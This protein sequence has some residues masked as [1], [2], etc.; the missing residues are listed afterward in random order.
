MTTAKRPNFFILLGLNPDLPWNQTQFENALRN[1]RNDWS[2]QGAG[3]ARQALAAKQNLAL[4]PEINRVMNNDDEREKEADR[5]RAELTSEHKT[6][7]E[8]FKKHLS[9]INAKDTIEEV[10]VNKFIEDFKDV[11]SAQEIKDRITIKI[12]PSGVSAGA[13]KQQLDKTKAKDIADRLQLLH[14]ST[15]YEL[16][17]CPPQTATADLCRAAEN[18]YSKTVRLSPTAEVTAK[19]E[20]AGLAKEVFKSNEMRAC[21]DETLRQVSLDRLL[22]ELDE[23]MARSTDKEVHSKQVAL[24]LTNAQ[25]EGW[26]EQEARDKLKEHARIRKWFLTL[27]PNDPDEEKILCPRCETP[28]SSKQR[29]CTKCNTPLFLAC[30]RCSKEVSYEFIICDSCQF[31]VGNRYLVDNILLEIPDHLKRD[32]FQRAEELIR[33]AEASWPSVDKDERTRKINDYKQQL[34]TKQSKYKKQQEA[35]QQ[36]QKKQQEDI[37]QE[38]KKLTDQVDQFIAQKKFFLARE[39]LRKRKGLI[40]FKLD[41]RQRTIDDAIKRAQDLFQPL[42]KGGVGLSH[43]DK[44]ELCRQALALCTDYQEALD[45]LPT[46]PPSPPGNL[47]VKTHGTVVS[48]AWDHSSTRG[49][50]YKIVRKS[51]TPPNSITDGILLETISRQTY[52]DTSPEIGL[53]LYYAVFAALDTIISTRSAYLTQPVMLVQDVSQFVIQ[54]D[55]D[56]VTLSWE[57]PPHVHSLAIVRKEQSS[58]DKSPPSSL[59]DGVRLPDI[60]PTQKKVDDPHVKNDHTYWYRIYCQFKDASGQIQTSSGISQEAK[61]EIPPAPIMDMKVTEKQIDNNQCEVHIS[62]ERPRKGKVVILKSSQPLHK[63][64]QVLPEAQLGLLG[65][66]LPGHDDSVTE[67]WTQFGVAYYTPLVIFKQMAYIGASKP[68]AYIENVSNLVAQN[69]GSVIRLTWTWPKNCQEVLIAYREQDYSTYKQAYPQP[70]DPNA[71]RLSLIE[72][73]H[74]GGYYDIQ[75]RADQNYYIVVAAIIMQGSEKIPAQ[76]TRVEALLAPKTVLIYEIKHSS[77]IR[78]KRTL[79]IKTDSTKSLPSLL[80]ISKRDGLPFDKTDGEQFKSIEET[81]VK[82]KEVVINLPNHP[83]P[84]DTFCKLFLEEDLQNRE[85]MIHHPHKDKLRLS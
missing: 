50:V 75:G 39:T 55:S 28:N 7:E 23:I 33:D 32:N 34:D 73:D 58:E 31:P 35:K 52:D 57:P 43:D 2:R 19:T 41:D 30:P 20:L 24:F 76:G 62:W 29:N 11:F 49:S 54:V 59:S 61:P 14:M 46:L 26:Q 44:I 5:A 81:I 17:D 37:Q 56:L 67:I 16:L 71:K 63:N 48:L 60:T 8:L 21:Y 68:Y 25:K 85:F 51:S 64:G 13:T 6:R 82:K 74:R 10:E 38:R 4:I 53:P 3:V 77:F 79:H 70:T 36:E 69:L 40:F 83:L 12:Q 78:N 9:F 45:L 1:K 27:P 66:S 65:N 42:K 84:P 72:Y 47:R 15:L 18:L 22:K 80:L